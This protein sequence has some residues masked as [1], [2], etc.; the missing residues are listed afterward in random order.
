[1]GRGPGAGQPVGLSDLKILSI[2]PAEINTPRFA[3]SLA[4]FRPSDARFHK[5]CWIAARQRPAAPFA[6]LATFAT[7]A[8][9]KGGP[10][11]QSH[12]LAC[13]T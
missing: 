11:R 2:A 12:R 5:G 7:A 9:Q 6:A 3:A 1:M 13:S 8:R 10:A 4:S